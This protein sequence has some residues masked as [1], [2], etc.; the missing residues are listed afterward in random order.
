ME[1]GILTEEQLKVA[2]EFAQKQGIRLGDAAVKLD[3]IDPKVLLDVFGQSNREDFFYVDPNYFPAI[4]KNLFDTKVML[5]YGLLPLGFKTDVKFFRSKKLLN[6]GLLSPER[7]S[8]LLPEVE[9]LAKEKLGENAF[10]EVKVYLILAEQFVEVMNKVYELS[11]T[12]IQ[13]T[14]SELDERLI[15]YLDSGSKILSTKFMQT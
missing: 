13:E 9:K 7:A 1:K 8:K 2:L 12:G 15:L 11:E 5:K 6:I 3:L 4:T 14:Q 10:Q